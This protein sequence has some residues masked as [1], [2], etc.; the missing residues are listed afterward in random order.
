MKMIISMVM[1]GYNIDAK[2]IY[3][4]PATKE[5]RIPTYGPLK[6]PEYRIISIFQCMIGWIMFQNTEN[7]NP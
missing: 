5:I 7:Q 2:L 4:Q 3:H 6:K 1:Y